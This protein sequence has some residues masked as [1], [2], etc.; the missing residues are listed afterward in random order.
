[1]RVTYQ[2]TQKDFYEALIANRNRR[3]MGKW[4]PRFLIAV[5]LLMLGMGQLRPESRTGTDILVPIGLIAFWAFAFWGAVWWTARKQF[6]EQPAV[7]GQRTAILD[8]AGVRTHW[9]GGTSDA[10]W[11]TYIGYLEAKHQFLTKRCLDADQLAE[12]RSLLSEH[13]PVISK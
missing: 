8:G 5:A 7:R 9:E 1:M 10:E 6:T 4:G 13:L 12:V 3:F 11:K 2:L